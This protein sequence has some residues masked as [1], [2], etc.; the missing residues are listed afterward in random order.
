MGLCLL[1]EEVTTA[2]SPSSPLKPLSGSHKSI[3]AAKQEAE[4]GAAAS[5]PGDHLCRC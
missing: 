2:I 1:T 3:S 5:L 4:G